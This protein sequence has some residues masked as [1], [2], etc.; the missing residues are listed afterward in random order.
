MESNDELKE[1]SSKSRTCYYSDNIYVLLFVNFLL[2]E[3]SNENILDYDI[4]Y[5]TLIDAKPLRIKFNK[6][7]GFIRVYDWNRCLVLFGYE[8]HSR[9]YN[10]IRYLANQKSSITYVI[11]H[12]YA[13][14]KLIHMNLSLPFDFA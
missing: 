10:R 14:I 1:I 11:S 2:D 12:N 4:S 8:K 6:V 3:E 7:D 13:R 9:I 5:Q